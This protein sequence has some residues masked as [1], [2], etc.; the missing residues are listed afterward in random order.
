[1]KEIHFVVNGHI[2]KVQPSDQYSAVMAL[3]INDS[4]VT[5]CFSKEE[6]PELKQRIMKNLLDA[7]EQRRVQCVS[8]SG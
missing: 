2:C 4:P 3:K 8:F 6:R 1:M 7:Y 5:V